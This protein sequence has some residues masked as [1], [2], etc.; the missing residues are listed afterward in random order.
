MYFF[1]S[2]SPRPQTDEVP[3][4]QGKRNLILVPIAFTSDHIETEVIEPNWGRVTHQE[5]YR[6]SRRRNG[7]DLDEVK[8]VL[9]L[10]P[11][12]FT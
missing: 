11:T 5:L 10:P 6:N 4:K 1:P 3:Y 7:E 12:S 9:K 8:S 2:L